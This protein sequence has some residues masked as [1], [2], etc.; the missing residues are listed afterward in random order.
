M[1]DSGA[2]SVRDAVGG[3][4]QRRPTLRL[5]ACVG[6][7]K[8]FPAVAVPGAECIC[9]GRNAE[10][11]HDCGTVVLAEH[12]AG[13]RR[14]AGRAMVSNPV[15]RCRGRGAAWSVQCRGLRLGRR[16][17]C[18]RGERRRRRYGK[19]DPD[20]RHDIGLRRRSP[21]VPSAIDRC[22]RTGRGRRDCRRA[23]RASRPTPCRPGVCRDVRRPT[24]GLR[25]LVI[26]RWPGLA[27]DRA[28]EG[29]HH[30]SR[31]DS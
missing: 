1:R 19:D 4:L 11:G 2:R 13:C 17:R 23:P 3:R 14:C 30:Q 31:R 21:M 8:R 10:P 7:G 16:I 9:A 5:A 18:G 15:A 27:P 28:A 25:S 26:E 12:T 6:G 24:V 29:L 22:V 20:G